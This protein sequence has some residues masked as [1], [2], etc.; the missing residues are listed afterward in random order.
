VIKKPFDMTK[1]A[2]AVNAALGPPS[3]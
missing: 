2:A 1:L 3:P